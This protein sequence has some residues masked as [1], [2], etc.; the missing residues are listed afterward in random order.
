MFEIGDYVV[1]AY[2]GICEITDIVLMDSSSL[3]EDKKYYLLIPMGEKT[4]KVYVP[5]EKAEQR[6]RKII[7]EA[8]AWQIID[9]IP[10]IEEI[11]IKNDKEREQK[12][13]EIL[14]SSD[15]EK[16]IG[17]I[18]NIYHRKQARTAQ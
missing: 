16:T 13:K 17:I 2:N 4:A 10:D 12:Y 6:F 3:N 15:L 7:K 8:Q 5:I 9:R 18:K 11:Q 14:R 1:N